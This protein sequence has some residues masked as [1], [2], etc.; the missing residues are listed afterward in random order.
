MKDR[1][2]ISPEAAISLEKEHGK[3]NI[4]VKP[5]QDPSK[6][7]T[8]SPETVYT[9]SSPS[10]D[11]KTSSNP[12]NVNSS[13]SEEAI[14]SPVQENSKP[15]SRLKRVV[16]YEEAVGSG[17]TEATQHDLLKVKQR[18]SS[19]DS[20]DLSQG[21]IKK[22]SLSERLFGGILGNHNNNGHHDGNDG[23]AAAESVRVIS[24]KVVESSGEYL[25]K[26]RLL[27]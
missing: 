18:G 2:L 16:S 19:Q 12:V 20:G 14:P 7:T 4:N 26:Q 9:I 15:P 1:S 23:K 13:N 11:S 8:S 5:I 10:L 3:E 25:V 6:N 21:Q 24:E 22:K 17:V 27:Y